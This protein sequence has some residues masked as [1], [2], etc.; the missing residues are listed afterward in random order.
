LNQAHH[1]VLQ[2]MN[3]FGHEEV[4]LGP[5]DL[6]HLQ[7]DSER[8][9]D[10]LGRSR[11]KARLFQRD[12]SDSPHVISQ[13]TRSPDLGQVKETTTVSGEWG[14]DD[15]RYYKEK[16]FRQK[17]QKSAFESRDQILELSS[18][19]RAA[20]SESHMWRDAANLEREAR[21][22]AERDKNV[23]TLANI[24][25]ENRMKAVQSRLSH[26]DAEHKELKEK[27]QALQQECKSNQANLQTKSESVSKLRYE[28]SGLTS[29][30]KKQAL[31]LK[32]KDSLLKTVEESLRLMQ[33]NC[34]DAEE[35]F[36]LAADRRDELES[37]CERHVI[38]IRNLES[39]VSTY[40][41]RNSVSHEYLLGDLLV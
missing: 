33:H 37:T 19:L 6:H 16:A 20:E 32:E 26:I 7:G 25:L 17:I 39:S 4:G 13:T 35:K 2:L 40:A 23:A 30:I 5:N 36:R 15:E 24:E 21:E 34:R 3:R 41:A 10:S 12:T 1:R 8:N 18:K 29:E 31:A 14:Q 9:L 27:F 38:R 11:L 28:A 22:Q